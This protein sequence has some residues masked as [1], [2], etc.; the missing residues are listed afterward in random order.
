MKEKKKKKKKI[1][2]IRDLSYPYKLIAKNKT[3]KF[4][5]NESSSLLL[6]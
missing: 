2:K 4:R 5:T 6:G 3:R 1:E